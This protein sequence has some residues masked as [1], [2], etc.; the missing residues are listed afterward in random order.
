MDQHG[1]DCS[2]ISSANPWLDFL[3]AT[4]A[5]EL[6]RDLN[7]DLESYCATGP[8]VSD[9]VDARGLKRLYGFG[10]LP[11]VSGISAAKLVETIHQIEKLPHLKGVIIGTRG[12][13][14]G[15]DDEALEPVWGA[16]EKTRIVAFIH[17][18]YGI[19]KDA[20]GKEES[21]VLPLALGFPFETTT[22]ITRMILA[23]V[24][25]RHPNL[26]ILLA[27]SGGVL[28]QLSSRI[29]SCIAHDPAVASRLKHDARAYLGMLYYDAVS[30]GSIELAFVAEVAKRGSVYLGTSSS[31][32]Q[33]TNHILWGT[34]HPFFPPLE[35]S[36]KWKSAVENL[37]AIEEVD[38]WSRE[39][40]DAVRGQNAVELFLID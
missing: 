15:L 8:T 32:N 24:L 11:L 22:A 5:Y 35:A 25:D 9:A 27:H 14:S 21:H 31:P 20:W 38:V 18:H 34:D 19:G 36:D 4:E 30:Y 12:L 40:K 29:A 26:R 17:P 37:E 39:Q 2:I 3:P 7:D 13:G 28:P 23:G 16:L 6:A 10:L 33:G 1:I